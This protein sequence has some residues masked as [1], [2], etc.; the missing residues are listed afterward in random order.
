MFG[1]ERGV[2]VGGDRADVLAPRPI[3]PDRLSVVVT[4]RDHAASNPEV[5]AASPVGRPA[6]QCRQEEHQLNGVRSRITVAGRLRAG[7]RGTAGPVP[8]K[9]GR[10]GETSVRGCGARDVGR[11]IHQ[12]EVSTRSYVFTVKLGD[13]RCPADGDRPIAA[14]ALSRRPAIAA[15]MLPAQLSAA[16]WMLVPRARCGCRVGSAPLAP[17]EWT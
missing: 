12:D 13:H 14:P 17:A 3:C 15:A 7:R 1:P 8:T 4:R 6:T 11:P 16:R 10:A 9:G 5:C 2:K